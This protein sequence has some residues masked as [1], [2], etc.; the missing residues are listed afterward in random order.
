MMIENEDLFGDFRQRSEFVLARRNVDKRDHGIFAFIQTDT[1]FMASCN[2]SAGLSPD[3]SHRP[4]GTEPIRAS[5]MIKT[6]FLRQFLMSRFEA[7]SPAFA[8][9]PVLYLRPYPGRTEVRRVNSIRPTIT[10]FRGGREASVAG[11]RGPG[12]DLRRLGL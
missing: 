6:D 5:R 3:V 2:E 12:I 7:D 10:Q 9:Y 8:P 4:D 11:E 1:V